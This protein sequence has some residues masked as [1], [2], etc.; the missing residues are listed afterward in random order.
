MPEPV[1]DSFTP[2]SGKIGTHVQLTGRYFRRRGKI[3]F[4][5]TD[6][7]FEV[8]SDTAISTTVPKKATTGPLWIGRV[9]EGALTGS[10]D[11]F[12][13]EPGSSDPGPVQPTILKDIGFLN[14]AGGCARGESERLLPLG[15]PRRE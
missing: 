4:N 12:H 14:K 13:V 11:D 1:I 15:P 10:R 8:L 7:V 9:G 2:M 5:N 6:A 3:Q